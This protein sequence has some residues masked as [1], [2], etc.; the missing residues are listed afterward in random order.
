MIDT[1]KDG[2]L[3]IIDV[4]ELYR[5]LGVNL[6]PTEADDLMKNCDTSEDGLVDYEEFK[7]YFGRTNKYL[8]LLEEK[9]E[10][11]KREAERAAAEEEETGQGPGPVGKGREE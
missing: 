1:D 7:A 6:T 4:A 10:Q 2:Y 9:E 3:S 11:V 8:H 5:R